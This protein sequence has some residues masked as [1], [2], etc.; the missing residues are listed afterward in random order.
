MTSESTGPERSNGASDLTE[1]LAAA[2]VADYGF[3]EPVRVRRLGDGLSPT[4]MVK[5][6]GRQAVARVSEPSVRPEAHVALEVELLAALGERGL[7]VSCPYRS[8]NGALYTSLTHPFSGRRQLVVYGLLQGHQPRMTP[9][10][11]ER[12]GRLLAEFHAGADEVA[13]AGS[14]PALDR[15][16]LLEE[17]LAWVRARL[18]PTQ[19]DVDAPSPAVATLESVVIHLGRLW[20]EA[21]AGPGACGIVHGDAHH[22]NFLEHDERVALFDFE[23]LAT[24]WR[25]YDLA[26][27]IWGTFGRGGDAALWEAIV[28]GYS[29]QRRLDQDETRLMPVFV[30]VR[31]LWW[32]GFHA[33]HWGRWR[34]PWLGPGF[35][36]QG[37]G[38]LEFIAAETC[39]YPR[40]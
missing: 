21:A 23:L 9:G 17:P 39:G 19:D 25:V 38:L 36:E 12:M 13:L 2:V 35:F 22:L 37:V 40:D 7:S 28:R 34:R 10:A 16:A 29:S 32:L 1:A 18:A 31:Q 14:P 15:P 26:T 11:G 8:N 4:F 24:G 33:R 6:P 20:P 27:L 30:A 3:A 5:T